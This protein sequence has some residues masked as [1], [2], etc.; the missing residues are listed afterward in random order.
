MNDTVGFSSNQVAKDRG[1][2]MYNR[3]E[4]ALHST[5]VWMNYIQSGGC[6]EFS[7]ADLDARLTGKEGTAGSGSRAS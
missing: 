4:L 5:A 3:K 7:E 1:K 6:V 2:G